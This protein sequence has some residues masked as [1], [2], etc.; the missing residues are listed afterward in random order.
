MT[1]TRRDA[2]AA[3]PIPE[4]PMPRH[5]PSDNGQGHL[6]AHRRRAVPTRQYQCGGQPIH[7]VP[8][9]RPIPQAARPPPPQHAPTVTHQADHA[10]QRD[11]PAARKP[12]HP[13]GKTVALTIRSISEGSAKAPTCGAFV[14][15]S[16]CSSS[17]VQWVWSCLWSFQV[18]D[19]CGEVELVAG[20][21]GHRLRLAYNNC[22][23][24]IGNDLMRRPVA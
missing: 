18:H 10:L 7:T 21:D 20:H 2:A 24:L 16:T 11:L 15:R 1:T 6:P 9:R 8:A 13:P 22:S 23:T 4:S 3:G 5:G 19:A 14:F 17:I 12:C